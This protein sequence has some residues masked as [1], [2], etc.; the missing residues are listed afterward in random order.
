MFL[1]R[2]YKFQVLKYKFQDLEHKFQDLKYKISKD[3]NNYTVKTKIKSPGQ[4]AL[5]WGL[6]II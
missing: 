3:R 1:V 5:T 4:R 2:K 6:M